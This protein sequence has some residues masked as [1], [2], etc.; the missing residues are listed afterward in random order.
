MVLSMES[1]QIFL[2]FQDLIWFYFSR[3]YS[4][5]VHLV[6]VRYAKLTMP[7]NWGIPSTIAQADLSSNQKL[8]LGYILFYHLLGM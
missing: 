3:L 7:L 6:Q 1:N 4:F 2:H 5:G 8:L